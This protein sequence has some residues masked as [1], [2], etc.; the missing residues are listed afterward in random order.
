MFNS[1]FNELKEV[2]YFKEITDFKGLYK[3]KILQRNKTFQKAGG[4]G[5]RGAYLETKRAS[6]IEPFCEWLTFSQ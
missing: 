1:M 5:G 6:T 4:G 2:K 3:C